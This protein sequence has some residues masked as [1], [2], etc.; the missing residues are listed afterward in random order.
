[1]PRPATGQIGR[2][3]VTRVL[4]LSCF[5]LLAAL[6]ARADTETVI[7]DDLGGMRFTWEDLFLHNK[8]YPVSS[9]FEY[10]GLRTTYMPYHSTVYL[11]SDAARRKHRW[12]YIEYEYRDLSS[13]YFDQTIANPRDEHSAPDYAIIQALV[14][15]LENAPL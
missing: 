1:M 2:L 11:D 14:F 6:P 9:Y 15:V 5:L 4:L 12:R 13:S 10:S 3:I 8:Y 7:Y